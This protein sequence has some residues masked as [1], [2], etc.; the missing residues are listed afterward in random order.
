MYGLHTD[1]L[2]LGVVNRKEVLSI[3]LNSL[4]FG[5]SNFIR[6]NYLMY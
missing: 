4:L 1:D 3:L 5:H 6:D 2:I